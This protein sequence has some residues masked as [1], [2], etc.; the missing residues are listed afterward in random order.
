[1]AHVRVHVGGRANSVHTL[2]HAAG[3]GA[4]GAQLDYAYDQQLSPNNTLTWAA[5]CGPAPVS[6]LIKPWRSSNVDIQA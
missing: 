5:N 4:G 2:Q 1:M 6:S 3:G